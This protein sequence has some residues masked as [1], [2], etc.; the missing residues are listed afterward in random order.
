MVNTVGATLGEGARVV[1]MGNHCCGGG[2]EGTTLEGWEA[3]VR[4][5]KMLLRVLM[6]ANWASPDT[7]NG[8][9]GCG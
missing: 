9:L 6:A 8:A 5:A 7:L 3:E 4:S 1:V 2:A